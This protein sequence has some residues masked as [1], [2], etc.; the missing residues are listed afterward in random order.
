MKPCCSP[1]PAQGEPCGDALESKDC[2]S[3]ETLH[4]FLISWVPAGAEQHLQPW[5]STPSLWTKAPS[6]PCTLISSPSPLL[7]P[8]LH[9]PRA[10]RYTL[11]NP[12]ATTPLPAAPRNRP[13]PA[14][15]SSPFPSAEVIYFVVCTHR[16]QGAAPCSPPAMTHQ[17][18]LPPNI[19]S[20][21]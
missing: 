13:P 20:G 16:K 12:S 17:I 15:G 6:Q 9:H 7:L 21:C 18:I 11:E 14:P 8:P 2:S 5:S 3:T 4:L 19:P 1:G 10:Q